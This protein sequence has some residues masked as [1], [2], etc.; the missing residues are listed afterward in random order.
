METSTS[1]LHITFLNSS[2][3]IFLSYLILNTEVSGLSCTR[4]KSDAFLN[5]IVM[6]KYS[7]KKRFFFVK[8]E[9]GVIVHADGMT[10]II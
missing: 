9:V 2:I 3:V 1:S 8:I 6:Q 7:S 10:K 4:Q 5:G